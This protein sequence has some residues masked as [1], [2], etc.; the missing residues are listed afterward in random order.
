M[1]GLPCARLPQ[2]LPAGKHSVGCTAEPACGADGRRMKD[3][4]GGTIRLENDNKKKK[5]KI[6]K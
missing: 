5:V 1:K 3:L 4:Y 2:T 6:S